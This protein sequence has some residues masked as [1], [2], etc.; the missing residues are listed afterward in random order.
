MSPEAYGSDGRTAEPSASSRRPGRATRAIVP[1]LFFVFATFLAY[2]AGT[3]ISWLA[4]SP[5]MP[6]P[7]LAEEMSLEGV[8]S[9]RALQPFV[10]AFCRAHRRH[11]RGV[12]VPP[13]ETRGTGEVTQRVLSHESVTHIFR[14]VERH[15]LPFPPQRGFSAG[16]VEQLGAQYSPLEDANKRGDACAS[17]ANWRD[18]SPYG[19]P[20]YILLRRPECHGGGA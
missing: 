1:M 17:E 8:L 6:A 16:T 14:R 7:D 5:V 3:A 11:C 2:L 20:P 13:A 18:S 9:F 19:E 12:C 10:A 15:H 4:V